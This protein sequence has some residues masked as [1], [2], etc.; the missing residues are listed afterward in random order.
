MAYISEKISDAEKIQIEF[1]KVLANT[2]RGKPSKWTIDRSS[3]NWLIC[4]FWGGEDD[5]DGRSFLFFFNKK[6]IRVSTK[7]KEQF[8]GHKRNMTWT[9]KSCVDSNNDTIGKNAYF[10][11]EL[12]NALT[13]YSGSVI[14]VASVELI[15][16]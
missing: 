7:W 5:R 8:D 13:A 1:D 9:I 10:Y 12:K 2:W 16:E 3:G 14:P 15:E 6:H 11:S 4:D